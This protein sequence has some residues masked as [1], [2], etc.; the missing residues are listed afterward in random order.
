MHD[1]DRTQ[2]EAEGYEGYE[3]DRPARRGD[4]EPDD[5]GPDYGGPVYGGPDY[6]GPGYR[7]PGYGR[8][9]G[10]R[11]GGGR[12][13]RREAELASELLE[14]SSEQEL[15]H[16][17]SDLISGAARAAGGF[18]RSDAGR[19][20]GGILKGAAK[21]AVP[22]IGRAIGERIAPGTGGSA[23]AGLAD[24]AGTLLGLELEG[25]SAEDREFEVSRQFVRFAHA[26]AQDLAT[27]PPGPSPD[28]AARAAAARAAA[29]HA[30]G[31]VPPESAGAHPGLRRR[32]GRW[33]RRGDSIVLL[34]I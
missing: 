7:R 16:F 6:S 33:V 25:L 21:Q 26:A 20:L 18:L 9:G 15:D 23:G 24:R 17:L 14:L 3:P 30:P 31:L 2:F 27:A 32:S 10:G 12:G 5:G 22:T 34:G 11:S 8:R 19:A 13:G 29:D 28:A 1:L 4:G